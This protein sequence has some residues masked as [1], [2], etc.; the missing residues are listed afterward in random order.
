MK[1]KKIFVLN[2]NVILF[3]W[4]SIYNFDEH[5]IKIPSIV[6]EELDEFKKGSN[7][8][9]INARKFTRIIDKLGTQFIENPSGKMVSK[10]S[11]GGISLGE[12]KGTIELVRTNEIA[13]EVKTAYHADKPDHYILSVAYE[14]SQKN[15]NVILVTKD[16][17]LRS[18]A[19]DIGVQAE[20]YESEQIKDADFLYTGKQCIESEALSDTINL[21]YQNGKSP[22]PDLPEI[23]KIPNQYLILKNGKQSVL[24]KVSHK[25]S[26]EEDSKPQLVKVEKL[27]VSGITAKNSEQAFAIDAIMSDH[28]KLVTLYGKAG[29]GKTLIAIACALEKL[30]RKECKQIIISAAIVPVGNK[31]VG[32]LPGDLYDKISPYMQGLYDNLHFVISEAKKKD[33]DKITLL[34]TS[35]KQDGTIKI[36]A[37]SSIR[38]RSINNSVFIVDESQN[39]TPHEIKTAITRAGVNT[40]IILCGDIDQIDAPYLGKA[41][42]GLS[43]VIS[44]FKG[45]EIY[46]N[47]YLEKGERSELATIASE[48]L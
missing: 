13:P 30:K 15:D 18:K 45:K 6:L 3:N 19:R 33:A 2:T 11:N 20:D 44:K 9:N 32:F 12:K 46:A 38:G 17:N 8:V 31:D 26:S 42:N 36:Q 1:K 35:S 40:Q 25:E 10:L 24:A 43:H 41:D 16:V 22:M 48:I 23:K 27:S 7:E 47:V 37:L 28:I 5:D 4:K 39:T 34:M 29:T 14:L 21:L